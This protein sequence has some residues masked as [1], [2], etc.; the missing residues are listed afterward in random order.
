MFPADS[1]SEIWLL[2]DCLQAES[3]NCGYLFAGETR[4]SRRRKAKGANPG[5]SETA[6]A[7]LPQS[8]L[9]FPSH[10]SLEEIDPAFTE[11]ENLLTEIGK[12]RE[13]GEEIASQEET[14]F[15]FFPDLQ[16]FDWFYPK[17]ILRS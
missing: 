8:Q 1:D 6:S 13:K 2:F 3:N 17:P 4:W 12:N 14:I 9:R 16:S 11:P 10:A 7:D 15:K 5:P